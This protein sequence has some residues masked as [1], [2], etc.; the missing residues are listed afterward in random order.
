[1]SWTDDGTKPVKLVFK[2]STMS[3]LQLVWAD[4]ANE[5]QVYSLLEPDQQ[6]SQDTY[7]THIW[8][9]LS[10]EGVL[11]VEYAGPSAFVEITKAGVRVYSDRQS[12]P[13]APH[14]I[15]TDVAPS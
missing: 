14:D 2:N 5:S 4:Y 10:E 8:R 12:P 9:V 13:P 11:M 15:A 1:M 7:S 6:I 3:A